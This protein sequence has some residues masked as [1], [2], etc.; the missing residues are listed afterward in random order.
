MLNMMYSLQYNVQTNMRF[1][2]CKYAVTL[3]TADTFSGK[4]KF[5]LYFGTADEWQFQIILHSVVSKCDSPF[6]NSCCCSCCSFNRLQFFYWI[7][8][9]LSELTLMYDTWIKCAF[10][11]SQKIHQ[12]QSGIQNMGCQMLTQNQLFLGFFFL[13]WIICFFF[14]L[15]FVIP[16]IENTK[17]SLAN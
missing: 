1:Q 11:C 3:S 5:N 6:T 9:I 2:S 15:L 4:L 8:Y 14:P 17:L 12:I 13:L 16:S 10:F 7:G